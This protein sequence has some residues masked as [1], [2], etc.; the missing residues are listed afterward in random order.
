[1]RHSFTV[2]VQ[3]GGS[4]PTCRDP[5]TSLGGVKGD[6]LVVLVLQEVRDTFRDSQ[7]PGPTMVRGRN[8]D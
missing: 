1:M 8:T 4:P 7:D 5:K 2:R 3:S 6:G